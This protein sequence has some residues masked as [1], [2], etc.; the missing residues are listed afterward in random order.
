VKTPARSHAWIAA[1]IVLAAAALRIYGID[2]SLPDVFEE[3]TPLKKAWAMWR[4]GQ[5]GGPDF[6]PHFFN[7]PSL[8]I[9][10]QWAAQAFLYAG[11]K[12]TGAID[13]AVDF[14][15]YYLVDKTPFYVAGR[16]VTALFG[17]ATVWI[18]YRSGR[19]IAGPFASSVAAGLLAVNAFHISKSQV[20]EVDVPLAFFVT[21][22]LFLMAR[23]ADRP[24]A[25][26]YALAGTAVGL[27]ASAKYPGALLVFPF[28][29]AHLLTYPAARRIVHDSS[30]P[31]RSGRWRD[32]ALGAAA[33]LAAFAITSPFVFLDWTTFRAHLS[34]E[35]EHMALG[36]FGLGSV[37]AWKSYA[38]S[39]GAVELG[40]PL[41]LFGALGVIF[42]AGL[43][44]RPWAI[45]FAA[46]VVPF[47][48][49]IGTWSMYADRYLLPVIPVWTL[50]A[51]AFLAETPA[52]IGANK[53][54]R[55][56]R[57]A[58]ALLAILLLA[59]PALASLSDQLSRRGTD[60]RTRAREWIEE[61]A[62][63]WALVALEHHG[64]EFFSPLAFWDQSREVQRYIRETGVGPRL[65]ATLQI[66]LFAIKPELSEVFYD[67]GLY[68]DADYV[69]TSGSVRNR[70]LAEPERFARQCA[71]YDSL[72]ANFVKAA[73]Y[74]PGDGPGPVVTIYRNPAHS[75]PFG[76]R[77]A[78][79]PPADIASSRENPAGQEGFFYFNLGLDYETFHFY[80]EALAS[81]RTGFGFGNLTP[82]VY[83]FL[84]RGIHRCLLTM[85]MTEE[86]QTFLREAERAAPRGAAKSLRGGI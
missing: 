64:P 84:A 62:P 54:T 41:V 10:L 5:P 86:A 80:P 33:A 28:L 44:R 14:Q 8:S 23:L 70:Y 65:Y 74:L 13:S 3:A 17:I 79:S 75:V 45:V 50:V 83:V 22:S 30:K 60:T 38:V 11:M 57:V 58:A 25:G 66:P 42:L 39:L 55:A 34:L 43:K 16:L 40:W 59:L 49:I 61:N 63:Q 29:A 82:E 48:A 26:V 37:P 7:Y 36:H 81:Y 47:L 6:N 19:R 35:R 46:F 21:L 31:H 72:D 27:A 67:L 73:E 32:F 4:W 2:W 77:A 68:E 24:S 1:A 78:A 52:L 12:I 51:L 56:R 69:I 15:M 9:Y 53:L 85:G 18:V 71:F 76:K 20:I